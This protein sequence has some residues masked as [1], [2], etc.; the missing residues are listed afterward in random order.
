MK[1]IPWAIAATA[2]LV[3]WKAVHH[4][5]ECD[6]LRRRLAAAHRETAAWQHEA[7]L[8]FF[9]KHPDIRELAERTAA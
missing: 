2:T 4:E 1:V 7:R 5:C 8:Y 3:A 6:D 9:M